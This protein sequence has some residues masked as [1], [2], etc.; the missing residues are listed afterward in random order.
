[1]SPAGQLGVVVL[2]TVCVVVAHL[3]FALDI[4]AHRKAA[5][6]HFK[7]CE[8]LNERMGGDWY[9]DQNAELY[10]DAMTDRTVTKGIKTWL[11]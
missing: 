4:R 6:E 3:V 7:T 8:T 10:R 9:Y 2:L 5:R 1:M 11:S